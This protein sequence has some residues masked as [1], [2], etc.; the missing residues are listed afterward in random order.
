[1]SIAKAGTKTYP[2]K[3]AVQPCKKTEEQRK[4]EKMWAIDDY[5]IVSPGEGTAQ[6]FL[7][8]AKPKPD[9]TCIDF[10]C[11]T[12]RGGLM[13]ALF[14]NMKVTLLDFA[15]NA[16]DEEV[17]NATVTQPGR[18]SFKQHDLNRLPHLSAMYGYCADVME[19][20]PPKEVDRVLANILLSAQHVFFQISTQPDNMG[21]R[22]GEDL[23]LT[24]R[25]FAWWLKKFREQN[26]AVHWSHNA[27]DKA[28]LFYVSS[29]ASSEELKTT[30]CI[31]TEFEEIK[32]NIKEN[33]KT[34]WQLVRPY[35]TQDTEVMLICGGPSLTDYTDEIIKLRAQGMPMITT[36]GTYNWALENGMHPSMQLIIDAREFNKRFVRPVVDDCK[37][38]IASQCHPEVLKGLPVDRTFLWHVSG[39][40]NGI[41]ELLDELYELWFSV[42]GGSTVT[43]RGLC[44]LRMLGFHKIHMYGFDSCYRDSAHH[45]YDQPENDYKSVRVSVG[46]G[47][48]RTFLCDAWMYTQAK[49]FLDMVKLFGDEIDLNIKGDGLIAHIIET[50]AKLYALE[51]NEG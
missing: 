48:T 21:K 7:E 47:G 4:Y 41:E 49:E 38:I 50:G 43:L 26:C 16:L 23:H 35:P 10:G 31:N 37:Y 46:C 17:Y 27:D 22:I 29:W 33:A 18:I 13:L 2:P 1:M 45:A 44:L 11:G 19:H 24:V 9:S 3:V 40:D 42:P 5:R 12:G 6:I 51:E 28:C 36:N 25:P 34:P 15:E 14:G 30:G 32:S 20:I 39:T 8:Q